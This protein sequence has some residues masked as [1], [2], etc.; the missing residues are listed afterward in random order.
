MTYVV[1]GFT[2]RALF[3]SATMIAAMLATSHRE[4]RGSVTGAERGL[5][6]PKPTSRTRFESFLKSNGIKLC[7]LAREAGFSKAYLDD[8]SFGRAVPTPRRALQLLAACQRFVHRRVRVG[9]LF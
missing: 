4:P 6:S 8:L 7:L 5:V 9:D 3:R 1:T 2:R